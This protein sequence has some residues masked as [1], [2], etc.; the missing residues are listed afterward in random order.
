MQL[1]RINSM[2]GRRGLLILLMTLFFALA[3]ENVLAAAGSQ[4]LTPVQLEHFLKTPNVRSGAPKETAAYLESRREWP[5]GYE[6]TIERFIRET[7]YE[8]GRFNTKEWARICA[9]FAKYLRANGR[10]IDAELSE[11]L[12]VAKV[13]RAFSNVKLEEPAHEMVSLIRGTLRNE[14]LIL[15]A[16]AANTD[17]QI[18]QLQ[19]KRLAEKLRPELL[20]AATRDSRDYLFRRQTLRAFDVLGIEDAAFHN[21]LAK[22]LR[23]GGEHGKAALHIIYEQIKNGTPTAISDPVIAAELGS[24]RVDWHGPRYEHWFDGIVDDGPAVIKRISAFYTVSPTAISQAIAQIGVT[25]DSDSFAAALK[26][27]RGNRDEVVSERL[28]SGMA[29]K[30][31]VAIAL[32]FDADRISEWYADRPTAGVRASFQID[33]DKLA[34]YIG[35]EKLKPGALAVLFTE[36]SALNSVQPLSPQIRKVITEAAE[37]ILSGSAPNVQKQATLRLVSE[38]QIWTPGFESAVV[39]WLKNDSLKLSGNDWRQAREVMR[40]GFN[41]LIDAQ[42]RNELR[43][44]TIEALAS[45]GPRPPVAGHRLSIGESW[46]AFFN[47]P[48]DEHELLQK[49]VSLQEKLGARA[50]VENELLAL[51]KLFQNSQSTNLNTRPVMTVETT[52]QLFEAIRRLEPKSQEFADALR[53]VLSD[54]RMRRAAFEFSPE[55]FHALQFPISE[56]LKV[57]IRRLASGKNHKLDQELSFLKPQSPSL[58]GFL[59]GLGDAGGEANVVRGSF[60][61]K[62]ETANG[63]ESAADTRIFPNLQGGS[64]KDKAELRRWKPNPDMQSRLQKVLKA[65]PKED[66]LAAAPALK[67]E[68]LE[69]VSGEAAVRAEPGHGKRPSPLSQ[70]AGWFAKLFRRTR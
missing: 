29:K 21:E 28:L 15:R 41:A 68:L 18:P 43:I 38:L 24:A 6:E 54:P 14:P 70:C 13:S 8:K 36:L 64:A 62:P 51:L 52:R 31:N 1:F 33:A 37:E 69:V 9:V 4:L 20:K 56:R 12:A 11:H 19:L 42:A 66:A 34:G 3:P 58:A 47:D 23:K 2:A 50:P 22:I 61:N 30:E 44:E 67:N 60:P 17:G 40:D 55:M 10:T 46:L 5:P 53:V 26:Y 35:K 57:E 32:K 39:T 48:N 65:G 27:L 25:G 59:S 49:W 45:A 16:V 7:D 63:M